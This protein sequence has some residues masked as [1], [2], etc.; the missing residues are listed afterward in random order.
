MS[1]IP[2]H[3]CVLVDRDEGEKNTAGI[4]DWMGDHFK[5]REEKISF[6]LFAREFIIQLFCFLFLFSLFFIQKF[7]HTTIQFKLNQKTDVKYEKSLKN[8]LAQLIFNLRNV[9]FENI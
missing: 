7:E 9:G 6:A 8:E 5:A 4:E 2:L 1:T 3:I